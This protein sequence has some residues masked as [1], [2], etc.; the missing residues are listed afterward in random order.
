MEIE[1]LPTRSQHV[2]P[3]K[4]V[5][6]ICSAGQNRYLLHFN[7]FHSLTQWTAAI[8]LTMFEHTS[9]YEAYTGSIIAGKGKNLNNIRA[10]LERCR[11]KHE[12]WA[13]V[14]FG[15]GTPWRRCWFVIAPPDEKEFQKMQKSMKKRSAYDRAP[16]LLMGTITFYETKKTKKTKPIATINNAYAAYAIYP[17]SQALIEQ[18]TLV[19]IEGQITTHSQH[20]STNEGFVFVMPE[21]H[22][23]VSG[24]EILLRFLVPTFDTFSLY[25]RPTRLIAETNHL[26]SIMFAFPKERHYGYL[27]ILDVASLMQ[28][29]GSQN[30]TEEEWRKQL[31]EATAGRMAAASSRTSSIAG[32][33]SRYRASLPSRKGN[34][35]VS[36]AKPRYA[37]TQIRSDFNQSA[38]AIIPETGREDHEPHH[39]RGASD[40]A[41]LTSAPR[42]GPSFMAESSP[43]SS[44]HDLV[45][46]ERGISAT[47]GLNGRSS[48]DSGGG[49][50]EGPRVNGI[51]GGVSPVSPPSPV[52]MPPAFTHG[53]GEM[54]PVR[55]EPSPDLRKA[56]NRM[57]NATLDQL[58][59]AG[60][61]KIPGSVLWDN[62]NS[63]DTNKQAQ[64]QTAVN[65]F[66]G[67]K[68]GTIGDSE[69]ANDE[70]T[71][72][73]EPA[74]PVPEHRLGM[75]SSSGAAPYLGNNVP[76]N[77]AKAVKRKPI[78]QR[79]SQQPEIQ[80]PTSEPSFDDLR[81]T[82]DYDVL[83]QVGSHEPSVQSPGKASQ[84]EES[85]YDD[86]S[87]TSPDYASTHES[88]YSKKS[89][90]SVTRPRMGVMKTV[91]NAPPTKDVQIGDARYSLNQPN[92][93]N[94]DIP[95]VDFGPTLSYF[96]TTGRPSTSD[97]M[98]VFGHDRKESDATEKYRYS[99]PTGPLDRHHSK[100]P[101]QDQ[102]RRS[103]LW[104]PGMATAPSGSPG[105]AL[106]PEQYV[107]QRATANQPTHVHHR[108]SS[109]TPPPQRTPSGDWTAHSRSNSH[110]NAAREMQPRPH[111]RGA[112]STLS[113]ND[114]SSHLTAR[115]QEHVARMTG[116][117]FFNLSSG[118]SKQ[119][120]PVNPMG[121]VG[122]IDAR[123]REKQSM[124]GG[125]SNKM[126]QHA[127]AQ[128][129]HHLLQQQQQFAPP[130]ADNYSVHPS[131]HS[132]YN[133]PT[134]SRTWDALNYPNRPE[135]QRRQSWYGHLSLP[136]PQ[137]P[138]SPQSPHSAPVY[139]PNQ[140][141]GQ[142]PGYF[143]N[144]NN[145]MHS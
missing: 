20:D 7:S 11:F 44:A 117:S 72:H 85:I 13:R 112:G 12:D 48:S 145:T 6:S 42:L 24:F 49:Q 8:R 29:P 46:H 141:L 33:N 16:R 110:F 52:A 70:D 87:T 64:Q 90:K 107:Q 9:L 39:T 116:S 14:R 51:E 47:N 3:L 136:T 77:T 137:S 67:S 71:A 103:V 35:R 139:Q 113:Y 56:N 131:R 86:A 36:L 119:Q 98:K 57:S 58:A 126:V 78:P 84:D 40:V 45:Q 60:R 127:I 120:A 132:V 80:S 76:V 26:K 15:A 118:N 144:V 81:H 74:T 104:Q 62:Q 88:V 1:T 95:S 32:S 73:Q 66:G 5:L 135:D 108:T 19:K 41:G 100:S 23:A 21:A 75:V 130:P 69:E 61:F 114:I 121:L 122:A 54:P 111:S 94:P 89:V 138:Q 25:G 140:M 133:L 142:H 43:D 115:E 93:E 101:S 102:S 92:R 38:D 79:Q 65:G 106:S 59:A 68:L 17:Q 125:M 124:K 31:K 105:F 99:N 28:T 50:N 82:I 91:G 55:P 63:G 4:N 109:N 96:P 134:A 30:W 10:I 53:P 97:T 37:S 143:G 83:N 22:P 129:Q 27:D 128:R 123:E 2:Q 34:A 18:S